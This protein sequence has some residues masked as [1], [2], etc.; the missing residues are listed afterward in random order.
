LNPLEFEQAYYAQTVWQLSRSSNL[1]EM[2][3]VACVIRN[4]VMPRLGQ[5]APYKSF[6][7]ACIDF[8]KIY[9]SR[10]L[11]SLS[12]PSFVS[13]DG[14]LFHLGRIYSC[15]DLDVTATH[16]HPNGAR[17]FAN[18]PDDW[19]RTEIIGRADLH[20]LLGTWGSMQ[21]YG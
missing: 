4:H 8:R 16:D 5:I 10:A 1:D 9:P 14:L 17:Y 12:D 13:M 7:E 2:L 21:F 15:E 6:Y 20:P 19:F 11:P 18:E 3:A